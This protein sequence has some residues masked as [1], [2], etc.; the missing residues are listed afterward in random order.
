MHSE[1][2]EHRWLNRSAH[3]TSEGWIRY[4]GCRCGA[5]RVVVGDAVIAATP[6]NREGIPAF[7]R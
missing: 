7:G 4:A 2:H 6:E 5:H 1:A 3:I